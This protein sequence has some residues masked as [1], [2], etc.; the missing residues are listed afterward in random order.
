[1][2]CTRTQSLG[3][4]S[5]LNAIIMATAVIGASTTS[6]AASGCTSNS[7]LAASRARWTTVLSRPTNASDGEANCRLYAGSF[8]GLVTLRQDTASCTSGA[9]R[10]RKLAA[11]D[12]DIDA[13]NDLLATKCGG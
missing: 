9:D 4:A 5:G 13:F 7:D 12:S 1:M 2:S 8:Y 6:A 3:K 11:L 10:D